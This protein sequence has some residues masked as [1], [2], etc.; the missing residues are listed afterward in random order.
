MYVAFA[1]DFVCRKFDYHC[2]ESTMQIS[3]KSIQRFKRE[4]K[5]TDGQSSFCIYNIYLCIQT[6]RCILVVWLYKQKIMDSNSSSHLYFSKSISESTPELYPELYGEG[7]HQK[8]AQRVCE[9]SVPHWARVGTTAQDLFLR[10]GRLPG[11]G[12]YHPSLYQHQVVPF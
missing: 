6:K 1:G 4:L 7:K 10:R 2:H 8:P 3:S 5:R 11:S 12:T 9:V